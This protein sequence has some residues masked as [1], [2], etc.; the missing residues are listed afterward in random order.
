MKYLC[1]MKILPAMLGILRP[2]GKSI[3]S[4][5]APQSPTIL[6][7]IIHFPWY[8]WCGQP[9]EKIIVYLP[10]ILN[11]TTRLSAKFLLIM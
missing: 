3:L 10:K 9:Q 6:D 5:N 1:P 8:V 7:T 11:Y 2:M 4:I